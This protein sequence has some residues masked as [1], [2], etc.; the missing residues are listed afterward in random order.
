LRCGRNDH[1]H[2]D[3]IEG[4]AELVNLYADQMGLNPEAQAE[5]SSEER[6]KQQ[7]KELGIEQDRLFGLKGANRG[8]RGGLRRGGRRPGVG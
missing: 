5:K 7:M 1:G 6:L 8:L 2:D 4:L 3:R